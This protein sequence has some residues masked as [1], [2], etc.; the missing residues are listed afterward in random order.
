MDKCTY[1]RWQ[2]YGTLYGYSKYSFVVLTNTD[3]GYGVLLH[4]FRTMY[5]R[6][7][8]LALVQRASV[9]KFSGEVTR[10]SNLHEQD[11]AL[12]TRIR[13]LYREYIRFVNQ[14]YFR[15]VTA[16]EQ[17]IELYQALQQQIHLKEQVESLDAEI[18]ELHQY[19]TL[20]EDRQQNDKLALITKIGGMFLI[21]SLWVGYFGMNVFN[22]GINSSY[23][24]WMFTGGIVF[25]F[26]LF[27]YLLFA[28]KKKN[29]R[30]ISWVLILLVVTCVSVC[31]T[32]FMIR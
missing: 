15:E 31:M 5:S 21:P 3:F 2:E 32:Y 14:I 1:F 22:K 19:A 11:K 4:Q 16:Q 30:I 7:L 17:G 20:L 12:G 23:I 18:G 28:C 13:D 25:T 27:Y 6:M 26:L 10:L 8:E 24:I 29:G 9:L